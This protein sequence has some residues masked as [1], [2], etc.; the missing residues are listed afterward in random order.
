M[1]KLPR[2]I[3]RRHDVYA[4]VGHRL[5]HLVLHAGSLG[6]ELRE[7]HAG[8]LFV[9]KREARGA[10][11]CGRLARVKRHQDGQ[12]S[13]AIEPEIGRDEFQLLSGGGIS[14][15]FKALAHDAGI[16][17][18]LFQGYDVG[19]QIGRWVSW[20][21]LLAP[22]CTFSLLLL[23]DRWC[24]LAAANQEYHHSQARQEPH[25]FPTLWTALS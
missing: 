14:G 22:L 4:A 12:I 25:C 5:T 21:D 16:G 11:V 6:E 9:L 19:E 24:G 2:P 7:N 17:A 13:R 20:R 18:V 3:G 1:R 8:G 23:L 15:N 10:D